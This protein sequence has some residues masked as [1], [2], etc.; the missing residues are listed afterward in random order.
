MN[1]LS[2]YSKH[3]DYLPIRSETHLKWYVCFLES[4][5]NRV[6][7]EGVPTE[8][9]HIVPIDFLPCDWLGFQKD[10]KNTIR[11]TTREHIIAHLILEKVTEA[12][13]MTY[14][15]NMMV[16]TRN[17][18]GEIIRLTTREAA[19][20]R[21]RY[22]S[23]VKEWYSDY[24]KDKPTPHEGH[25]HSEKSKVLM[26]ERAKGRPN[27]NK[28]KVWCH[29]YVNDSL[30]RLS[31]TCESDIPN[32]W[33]K[34]FGPKGKYRGLSEETK[35]K[36]SNANKGRQSKNKGKHIWSKEQKEHLSMMTK[37]RFKNES[38]PFTGKHHSLETKKSISIKNKKRFESKNNHPMY[39]RKHLEESIQ[40]MRDSHKKIVLTDEWKQHISDSCRKRSVY[41]V[42][43]DKIYTSIKE[44]CLDTGSSASSI[45]RCCNGTHKTCGGYHWKYLD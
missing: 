10:E 26:R 35:K 14:A 1:L 40:K 41:C 7:P 6:I 38:G 16:N 42:E 8:V 45:I 9:H 21:D 18:Q 3:S 29:R 15:Y 31:V 24:Y 36:I 2:K 37:E 23:N 33:I 5:R 17:A 25:K 34:G 19:N 13:S 20:L 4:R 44:A 22:I 28:G 27:P 30:E 32:G 39:G 12:P 11:L 43:L